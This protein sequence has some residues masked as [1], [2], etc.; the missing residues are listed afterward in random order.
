MTDRTDERSMFDVIEVEIAPPHR[1]R[2]MADDMT[3]RDAE[4]YMKIAIA[5]RGVE[6]HFYK[7]VPTGTVK[8]DYRKNP[9]AS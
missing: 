1:N 8:C 5:R 4:A 2:L 9:V 3:E 7:V 6:H